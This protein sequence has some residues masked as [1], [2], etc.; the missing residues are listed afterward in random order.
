MKQWL[1]ALAVLAL[2]G[3]AL[4]WYVLVF[5]QGEPAAGPGWRP[6]PPTVEASAVSIG[7]VVRSV[8]AVGTLRANEAITLRPEIAGRVTGIHFDEGQPVVKG[9]LLISLDDSVY[10]AEVLEKQA[11]LRIA[12]LAFERADQLVK[13]R[14]APM[15]ERDR[16]LA[17]LQSRDASLQLARA[18]LDRT[19]IVAPFAGVAGLR[20]VS[21][22]DFVGAGQQ[23]VSLTEINPLKVDFRLGEVFLPQIAEGQVIDVRVDAWPGEVFSGSVFAIE[24]QVDVGGRAVVIRALLPNPEQK[25]RPGLF[26]RVELIVDAAAEAVLV[27]E[28]AIVPRGDLHFVYLLEDGKAL[29]TEVQLGKRSDTRVEVRAGLDRDAVVVT[30][31]QIKLRDGVSV[32]VVSAGTARDEAAART[33]VQARAC[34]I[35]RCIVTS[36]KAF[37]VPLR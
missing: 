28:A 9:D 10:R 4:A 14:A 23:L 21:V 12:E 37:A 13:K 16:K 7:S 2:G 19:R 34:A 8:E 22:G 11:D 33:R 1:S 5:E 35:W 20:H 25:L 15:E 18:R 30:A 24:P 26:S 36:E 6:L 31:G 27:P 29:L 32:R 3:A 17:E